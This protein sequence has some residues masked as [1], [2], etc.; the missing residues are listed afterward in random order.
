MFNW[1][2]K[3]LLQGNRSELSISRVFF[4]YLFIFFHFQTHLFMLTQGPKS[5]NATVTE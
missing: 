5:N 1:N 3:P 4:I 2:V